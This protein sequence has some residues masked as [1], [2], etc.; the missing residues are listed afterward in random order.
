MSLHVFILGMLMEKEHHPYD[1]KKMFKDQKIDKFVQ[2]G[3]GT[4]Y[5]AFD[6]LTKKGYIRP[7]ENVHEDKRPNKTTYTITDA[8]KKALEEEIYKQFKEDFNLK[9]LYSAVFFMN[10][11]DP[12]KITYLLEDKI[13][14]FSDRLSKQQDAMNKSDVKDERI[15][16]IADHAWRHQQVELEWLQE[17]LEYVKSKC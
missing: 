12:V 7:M 9:A 8:G 5:Y 10:Y 4:L 11:A 16:L 3:D 1:L 13:K 17:L 6:V 14:S 2:I 15:R